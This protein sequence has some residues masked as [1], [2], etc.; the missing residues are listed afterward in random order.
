MAGSIYYGIVQGNTVVL[1]DDV[2]LREGERV[3]VHL[4]ASPADPSA[5]SVPE[6]FFQQHLLE[7]GLLHEIKGP[8]PVPPPGDRTP[9]V[10]LGQ[11]LS[12]QIIEERR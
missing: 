10:V 4:L 2:H 3:E 11:P 5:A 1:S 7:L 9:I 8:A 12:E 6:D